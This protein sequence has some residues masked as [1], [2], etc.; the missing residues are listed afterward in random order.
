MA[1]RNIRN[2]ATVAFQCF[3]SLT[4]CGVLSNTDPQ[5]SEIAKF[6]STRRD[7]QSAADEL[8]RPLVENGHTPGVVAGVLLPDGSMQFFGYGLTMRNGGVKPDGDTLFAVG[9]L[10]KGFLAAELAL[11]VDEGVL[12]WDD[13]IAGLASSSAKLS[14][15][16]KQVTLLQLA[17]HT[18]GMPRQPLD[19]RT[20][21]FF[22]RYLFTG[23][24]FYEH[25]D[26]GYATNYLATFS[27]YRR[28]E[29]QYSNIGYGILGHLLTLR[30]GRPV[31]TSVEQRVIWPLGL[32]CTG[33]KPE[34]LPCYAT[35]AHGHAGDQ[36]KF[37]RRGNPTPDWQFSDLMRASAGL[38]STARDLLTMASAHMNSADTQLHAALAGN[39]RG[40]PVGS[41]KMAMVAWSSKKLA[42]R[43][44]AYQ[45]GLVAGYT[46]YIGMDIANR[47]AVV[48]LQNSF[49]WDLQMGHLLLL[50]TIP[51]GEAVTNR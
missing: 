5:P 49:N 11:L 4:G 34:N 41:G 42:G 45:V 2:C 21:E 36:P 51:H 44:I 32:R 12:S 43:T 24:S 15:D 33:Y 1:W 3:Y 7:L 20:L 25:F 46:S 30:T 37:I 6:E 28:G 13:T 16:A 23:E 9:S 39:A 40:R 18:A 47:T 35:R 10:S 17:T 38:H 31:E 27:S 29:L 48:I 19:L 26:R 8:I 14:D 50:R 22:V